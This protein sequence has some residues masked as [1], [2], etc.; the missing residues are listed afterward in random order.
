VPAGRAALPVIFAENDDTQLVLMS[1]LEST[2]AVCVTPRPDSGEPE[3]WN[4][5]QQHSA[6]YFSLFGQDVEPGKEYRARLRLVVLPRPKDSA[7]VHRQL[8]KTFVEDGS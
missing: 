2:S 6:L 7:A 1:E 5:V 3:E 4:S 8:Y